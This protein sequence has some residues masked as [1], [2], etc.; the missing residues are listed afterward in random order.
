MLETEYENDI[1]F[2]YGNPSITGQH[3]ITD[4][5]YMDYR[6]IMHWPNRTQAQYFRV[7]CVKVGGVTNICNC[8]S[9]NLRIS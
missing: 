6:E 3:R 2:L 1:L 7:G 9:I 8:S 5:L 4:A